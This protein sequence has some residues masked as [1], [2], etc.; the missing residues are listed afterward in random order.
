MWWKLHNPLQHGTVGLAPLIVESAAE[1]CGAGAEPLAH[2]ASLNYA[3]RFDRHKDS[4][5]PR[6]DKLVV[7]LDTDLRKGATYAWEHAA[8]RRNLKVI[9]LNLYAHW[10]LDHQL[11]T[12]ISFDASRYKAKSRY[13]PLRVSKLT[14]DIAK[15][16]IQ[17]EFLEYHQGFYDQVHP[18]RSRCSR[19]RPTTKLIA[20]FQE[21]L[22]DD[23]MASIGPA[24]ALDIVVL[25]GPLNK[26]GIKPLLEY[27]DAEVPSC[28][29]NYRNNL[30][31]ING[32]LRKT[33]IALEESSEA[34][35]ALDE[36][37]AR[38]RVPDFTQKQLYRVFNNASWEQG[39]RFYGGWWIQTPKRLRRFICIETDG[40]LSPTIELDY[41]GLHLDLLYAREG[42]D[43][44]KHIGDD[45]YSV[46]SYDSDRRM[47]GFVKKA[48][49]ALL[50]S[51][52]REKAVK[53]I[54]EDLYRY[55]R[56]L[57]EC[58]EER[59]GIN[60]LIDAFEAK[61]SPIN[62][63]FYSGV[64]RNLQ[65]TDSKIAERVMLGAL[66]KG[67]AV[68]PIHDSFISGWK[69]GLDLYLL[70]IESYQAEIESLDL[71]FKE[72]PFPRMKL[73]GGKYDITLR[74]HITSRESMRV[75]WDVTGDEIEDYCDDFN[76]YELEWIEELEEQDRCFFS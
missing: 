76:S 45:A 33:K 44:F 60:D 22:R 18:Q 41:S 51:D 75:G 13:N 30:K 26:F 29:R 7:R 64:G 31:H 34:K 71:P 50:N 69:R 9:I 57:V 14:V 49:N 39:G 6:F 72:L 35:D 8:T 48:G 11:Y 3:L 38:C 21:Y 59:G 42:I 19:I 23:A 54:R 12:A 15:A 17:S 67:F 52:S 36:A 25:K 63:Y 46:P 20:L 43:Y 24:I 40:E 65:F 16:L 37:K 73:G 5:D 61:H 55:H 10:R 47:R 66:D 53:A 4:S 70:M 2:A 27:K 68:L 1:S 32:A 56:H 74:E 58:V 28:V 62:G